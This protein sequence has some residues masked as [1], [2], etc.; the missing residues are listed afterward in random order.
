MTPA[1]AARGKP[2]AAQRSVN[3][4]GLDGI[5][6]ASGREATAKAKRPKQRREYRRNES[7]IDSQEEQQDVLGRIH[8]DYSVA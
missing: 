4:H 1:D 8:D 6:R 5:P 2:A 7:A 3:A